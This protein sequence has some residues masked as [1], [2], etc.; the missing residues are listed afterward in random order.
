MKKMFVYL[1]LE[2][3]EIALQTVTDTHPQGVTLTKM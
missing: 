3:T 2:R 1:N